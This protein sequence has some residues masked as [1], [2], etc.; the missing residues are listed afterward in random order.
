MVFVWKIL[1]VV[2]VSL[3]LLSRMRFKVPISLSKALVGTEE[4]YPTCEG[5]ESLRKAIK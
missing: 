3:S 5:Y 4:Y 1:R 2:S